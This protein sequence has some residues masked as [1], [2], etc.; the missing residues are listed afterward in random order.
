MTAKGIGFVAVP[1]R[2]EHIKIPP[3]YTSTAFHNDTVE[4]A[5]RPTPQGM[6][7]EGQVVRIVKRA[8]ETFVGTLFRA[9]GGFFLKPQDQKI[10][11]DFFISATDALGASV[12]QKVL[13]RMQQWQEGKKNP[14]ARVLSIIGT[15]GHNETE[16]KAIVLDRGLTIEFPEAV[17]KEARDI[18]RGFADKVKKELSTRRDMRAVTTFTIDPADAKD[19]DDAISFEILLNG[20]VQIGVH[21]ADVSAF[22]L[23]GTE[24]DNEARKRATSIYLVD[25]TIPMLPHELSDDM[26]SL[27]PDQERL[28][29]SGIFTFDKSALMPGGAPT[30]KDEWYGETVI[31]SQKRFSYE[32]AQ[33]VLDKKS[34][35]LYAELS[36]LNTIAYALRAEKFRNG[37]ISFETEEIKFVLDAQSRPIGIIKKE[38]GDTHKLVEDF[39]LLANRKIAEYAFREAEKQG[40]AFVY[41]IHPGPEA[42]KMETLA[43]FLKTLGYILP[44]K[45]GKVSSFDINRIIGEA[46]GTPEEGLVTKTM[47]RSMGK[48]IYSL[49]NIGHFGLAFEYYTHF[50]S[51]IRRYP[52]VMVHRLAKMYLAKKKIPAE[53]ITD[54]KKLSV[55]SSNMEKIAADAERGSIKYKQV[56]YMAGKI[57][58]AYT[59][60]I[61]GVT[62]WGIF[63]EEEETKSE[64]LIR[65][66]D[67]GNDFYSLD[68]KTQTI[69][70][71]RTG[72]KYRLGDTVKIRVKN[73]DVGK[74]TIDYALV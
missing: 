39:M 49:D 18:Q 15:P 46:E 52:D 35:T 45:N 9:D 23:P 33:E 12:G 27:V 70:G 73:V 24:L 14:E 67:L 25:R 58:T 3:E 5:L 6:Q 48:A 17:Q 22:V 50:T 38:R 11:V 55:H 7:Q 16:M 44:I 60:V 30:I 29:F 34:G 31:R 41:R 59:G 66:R 74:Q 68:E 63:I 28:T 54:Y 10:H 37:A 51:P 62:E 53:I 36:A 43:E 57:G 13:T 40:A 1:E 64:G 2:E 21:I 20:D 26:C 32:E 47:V 56:E 61:S 4:V 65:L 71:Q 42:Q 72:T 8:K 69:V 19:F